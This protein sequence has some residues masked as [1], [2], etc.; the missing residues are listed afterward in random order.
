MSKIKVDSKIIVEIPTKYKEQRIEPKAKRGR[1]CLAA[2]ALKRQEDYIKEL[3]KM[4]KNKNNKR[5]RKEADQFQVEEQDEEE[6]EVEEI[7]APKRVRKTKASETVLNTDSEC[8]AIVEVALIEQPKKRGRK[9]KIV[10]E[11]AE[12]ENLVVQRVE[13]PKRFTRA[14]VNKK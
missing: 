12:K 7:V 13:E 5:T 11:N 9:P 3:E 14:S 2:L 10:L 4:N 1:K 8:Q 6:E